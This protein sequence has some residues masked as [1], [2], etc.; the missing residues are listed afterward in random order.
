M[1]RYQTPDCLL[2]DM[3]DADLLTASV[4]AEGAAMK[5]SF[6]DLIFS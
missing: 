6:E 4:E 3:T 5:C 2:F 1:K